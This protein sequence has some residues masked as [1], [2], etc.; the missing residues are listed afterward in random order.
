MGSSVYRAGD[1]GQRVAG[2]ERIPIYVIIISVLTP[3]GCFNSNMTPSYKIVGSEN[4]QTY[5]RIG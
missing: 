2:T 5:F 3:N 4:M 1:E